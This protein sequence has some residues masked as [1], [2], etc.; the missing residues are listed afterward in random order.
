MSAPPPK[1]RYEHRDSLLAAIPRW[2]LDHP[3]A[4][5]AAF[6][7]VFLLAI[8]AIGFVMPRRFMPYVE[9][10]MLGIV[11]MMPGLSAYEMEMYVSKPIEEQMVNLRNV[12][13]VRS[14]SQ[15]GFSMVSL[16][17]PYGTNMQKALAEVQSLMN[18]VQGSLPQTGANL[19]PSWVLPI[20]PLNIPILSLAL[21]G[22]GWDPVRLR[23]F[24][25]N[26]VVRRLKSAPGV[27]SVMPFG[28]YR[29]QLQVVV[30]RDKLAR[31]G[32]SL[33]DVRTAIDRNNVN[34]S[35]GTITAGPNEGI[36]RLAN[37]AAS[38]DE[39]ARYPVAQLLPNGTVQRPG[40]TSAAG[41]MG[42]MGGGTPAETPP[43]AAA[44]AAARATGQ[45]QSPR[46]IRIADVARVED[47]HWE[48]RSAYHFLNRE[49]PS[50][51]PASQGAASGQDGAVRQA[52]EVAVIQ[53][54]EESSWKVIRSVKQI[55]GQLERENP[56]IKFHVAY[57]NSHFVA[58]LFRNMFEELGGAIL[59]C[60]LV[61]FLFLGEWRA[62]L[63]VMLSIPA[64]LALAILGLVPLGMSLN[65][66][67]L[68]GLLLSIGRLVDDTIID[69][70]AV[71]R[72]LRM[73][74]DPRTATI[75][76]IAEV[77]TAV[78]SSTAMILLALSPL[79]FCGGVVQLMF[80]ELV[81]PLMLA[82]V[83]S[84]VE[85]FT[86]TTVLCSWLLRR[87]EER[88]GEERLWLFRRIITP[89][90][91]F[92][93]RLEAGYGRSI[94]WML[95][96]RF[97]N[98]A[99]ILAT[100]I[101]G[102][103][104]YH[105]IGSEMMPLADVGQAYGVLEMRPGTSFA[106]T[107]RA[108]YAVEQLIAKHYPEIRSVSTEIGT[109]SMLEATGTYFTG[110]G[111]PL[112]NAATLMLTLSDK[113][114]RKRDIWQVIDGLQQEALATIPG[115][116]RFQ[117]KEMG[118][119][120]MASAQAPI[121]LVIS[122]PDLT[123][124]E[125][126]GQATARI[127]REVGVHQVALDWA[128]GLPEYRVQV[129]AARAQQLGL[130]VEDVSQQAYYALRGG[131]TNEFY[132]LP[133]LRQDTV[134][135]RYEQAQRGSQ[136]DLEH[137][138]LTTPGGQQVPL[139][140]VATVT[141]HR[142]PTMITHDGLR[143]CITVLGYYRNH[144]KPSMDLA[145][146]VQGRAM[147]ELNWPPGYNIEMRG[148]MTQMMDSFRRLMYGLALAV[149]FILLVLVAQ[150]RGFAQPLQMV[151]S[152]PLELAGVFVALYIAHQTFS[153]VSI[154]SIIVLTGM[155]I[156]TAILLVDMIMRY[157][158]RG[159]PRDQA[160]TEACPQRLRPIVMTSLIT[161]FVMA[162]VAFAP[163]TGLDAYAPLATVIIGG[164]LVGTI[165]SLFDIP[166]MHTYVDDMVVWLNRRVLRR[167]WHWPVTD[168]DDGPAPPPSP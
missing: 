1:V 128:S 107:E 87:R 84:M 111:V 112:V 101:I 89:F 95:K 39:V 122:G 74:K 18:V 12:R 141:R 5:I 153:S 96:H 147:A 166:I 49:V 133:N 63:I 155:D 136:Q 90:Q 72:H 161:I 118:S 142:A 10:P 21:T 36:V 31:Y 70:H 68:V 154:M 24:A 6:V 149:V 130:T 44:R 45:A 129:N 146:E 98:L 29:R 64:S 65:S 114:E 11:T 59:L 137:V 164:L 50:S 82:L 30:D 52:I 152:L 113:Q 77:R 105:F 93:D 91:G 4:V 28:G 48:R 86:Q 108:T 138:Y 145:M 16:E 66:G 85:S 2:S 20:D 126:L 57:D 69:V 32:L 27:F 125:K 51:G 88:A 109:E 38:A 117:I 156:T 43:A 3:M 53:N 148:D 163:K 26:E 121:S 81:W 162:S 33:L 168:K 115:I 58:I 14:T 13:Y 139:N 75:D 167:E 100:I 151:F 56:G 123:V 131:L 62:T 99:R 9:S 8:V 23:E 110:Y 47:T 150:F 160:I 120:V 25:D 67:T 73:G 40:G 15:D 7:G 132:R 80:Q 17:Y 78:I 119:D 42:G 102:F 34:R 71:E 76:G 116:R 22:E 140:T 46:V 159:V 61:L 94:G 134:L 83:F 135:V 144:E 55:L 79:L 103:G 143:R 106:E 41:G 158:D 97:T 157:R 19:K 92:L 124:L 54:P 37:L 104:F 165:L 60:G 127:A 35:G